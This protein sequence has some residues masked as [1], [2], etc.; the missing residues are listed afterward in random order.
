M[1]EDI[2]DIFVIVYAGMAVLLMVIASVV[3]LLLYRKAGSLLDSAK[4]TAQN[5][6]ELSTTLLK[7]VKPL[8]G[9]S[10]FAFRAG[11]VVGFLSGFFKK[12]GGK[13]GNGK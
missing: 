5:T 11:Q 8:V 4:N 10:A 6:E 2:R 3:L 9:G 7:V 12:K 1:I 13:K